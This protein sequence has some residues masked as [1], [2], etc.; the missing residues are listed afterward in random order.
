MRKDSKP[1]ISPEE[2]LNILNSSDLVIVD[3]RGGADALERYKQMHLHGAHFVSLE[4]D[5]SD[6]GPDAAQGGRHPLPAPTRFGKL[7][8]SL[9]IAPSS[10]VCVYD[11]KGGAN[12]AAR[13]WWMMKAVGHEQIQVIDGGLAGIQQAHLPVSHGNPPERTGTSPYPVSDWDMPLANMQLIDQMRERN[14]A[15]VIDVREAF[16]YRGESEPIDPVAGHIPGAVNIPY[17]DNLQANGRFR[18]PEE[19]TNLY[20]DI[21][22]D[23]DAQDIAVHCGSGVTACHTLL[24]IEAA[25]LST[26]RLYVGS[27][28]EWCRNDAPIAKGPSPKP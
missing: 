1:L 25:G 9:G 15:V 14:G 11:D 24:A 4:T 27:W 12:S 23:R 26:P 22:I 5:L 17:V 18:P 7:L 20:K 13:F 21:F 2:L 8:G 3:A 19:L 28:S 6:I 10:R 16:R